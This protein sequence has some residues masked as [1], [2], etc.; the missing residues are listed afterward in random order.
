[1]NKIPIKSAVDANCWLKISN[2]NNSKEGF[3]KIRLIEFRKVLVKEI[4][5][6]EL[7]SPQFSLS[8]GDIY[9]LKFDLVNFYKEVTNLSYKTH[10]LFNI[11]I[12]DQDNYKFN[13]ISDSH[14]SFNSNFGKISGLNNFYGKEFMPK[15]KYNGSLAYYLPK[16]DEVEYFV[17]NTYGMICEL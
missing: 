6:P 15:I 12:V 2:A 4:D 10:F 7:I 14:L 9:I 1:M 17:S 3:I 11:I 16:D 13:F 8:E 5:N